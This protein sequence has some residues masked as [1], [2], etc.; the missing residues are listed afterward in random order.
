MKKKIF[1][2]AIIGIAIDQLSKL[3]ITNTLDLYDKLT[4]IPNFFSITYI[5]NTG[6][7]WGILNN[8]I[9]LLIAIT[10]IA[11][12]VL[13]KFI[14]NEKNLNK[15]DIIAYGMLISGIIGN[16]IDRVIHN[17]VIDFLD[18]RIFGYSFP[19]FNIAD[20][21]I[22]M[23]VILMIILMIKRGKNESNSK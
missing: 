2:V 4:V 22:V 5:K 13:I 11:M 20:T 15:I 18:F 8:N 7:A 10:L 12:F 23:S 3:L 21:L 9:P 19:V 16:F 1:I 17:Y 14:V 6:A